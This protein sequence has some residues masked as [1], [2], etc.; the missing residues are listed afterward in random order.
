MYHLRVFVFVAFGD[1]GAVALG[2]A[3]FASIPTAVL[4]TP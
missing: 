3:V 4:D 2:I 1:V